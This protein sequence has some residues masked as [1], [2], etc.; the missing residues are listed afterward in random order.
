M[1]QR[2]QGLR[3]GEGLGAHAQEKHH[4]LTFRRRQ[5]RLQPKTQGPAA[6]TRLDDREEI[7]QGNSRQ[8]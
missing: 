1:A 7:I 6:Q 2:L 4:I 8:S 5:L 3:Q